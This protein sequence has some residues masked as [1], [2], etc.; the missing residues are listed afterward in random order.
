MKDDSI[1]LL[2]ILECIDKINQYTSDG[3]AAF[4]TSTIIQ[5]AVIRNLQVLAESS[6]NISDSLKQKYS[7]VDWKSISGF[8]NVV[9]HDYLGLDMEKMWDIVEQD[10]P[11]M[12]TTISKMLEQLKKQ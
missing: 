10:I 4:M 3:R 5:D 1:Y 12:K 8:R 11:N 2:H 9:V 7:T 6:Q